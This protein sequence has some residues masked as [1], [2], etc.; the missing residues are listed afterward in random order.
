MY[1][2]PLEAFVFLEVWPL[3]HDGSVLLS[4]IAQTLLCNFF[5]CRFLVFSSFGEVVDGCQWEVHAS[6]CWI[7][8]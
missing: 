3:G 7:Q 8:Y 2:L 4:V 6:M 5:V 1:P